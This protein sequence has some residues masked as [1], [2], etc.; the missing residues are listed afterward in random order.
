[1]GEV[2]VIMALYN[3]RRF[4]ADS[5]RSALA[6]PGVHEVLVVD[7]GSTDGSAETLSA[8][9]DPRLRV[10]RQANAGPGAARN[11]GL[12]ECA[13]E[14]VVFLDAD[15]QMLGGFVESARP[16]LE[17]D[18]QCA[19]VA[20]AW[21]A[22][23]SR[24]IEAE[25]YRACGI[26]GGRYR[27]PADIDGERFKRVVDLC[28]SGAMLARASVVRQ[29]GGF[30][31]RDRCTFG[32]D[33]FLWAQVMLNHPLWFTLEPRMWVNTAGSDLSVGRRGK[34]A[35]R[36]ILADSE[37]LLRATAPEYRGALTRLLEFY[38]IHEAIY[39]VRT[40]RSRQA[41]EIAQQFRTLPGAY[42]E[43]A[44]RLHRMLRLWWFYALRV[45]LGEMKRRL[46]RPSP[47]GAARG[48]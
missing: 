25:R 23:E 18:P 40:G 39:A 31:D 19:A 15:D 7:D 21:Y 4:V 45:R 12:R 10:L 1:M 22:G 30:Y 6:D 33:S 48:R 5:V 16:I 27:L 34:R 24:K 41:M 8:I 43:D 38:A 13:G 11:L 3:K 2:S 36:P 9:H 44:R 29:F 32:E 42:P 35:L 28:L 37:R 20:H 14:F 47:E 17:S 26:T 46:G